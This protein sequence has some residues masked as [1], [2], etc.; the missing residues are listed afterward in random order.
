MRR[1]SAAEPARISDEAEAQVMLEPLT[2][3][4]RKYGMEQRRR[5][6][7]LEE[8]VAAGYLREIPR[9]PAGRRFAIGRDLRVYLADE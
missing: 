4:V 9:A 6:A 1:D 7:T 3:A 2:Q 8:L 5:P